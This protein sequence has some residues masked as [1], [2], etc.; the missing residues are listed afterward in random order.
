MKPNAFEYFAPNTVKEAVGLLER[1]EDEAKILAGG[2]SLVPIMNFRLGRPEVLVDINGIKDL[3]YIKEKGEALLIGALTRER[4][5]E[6]S[7]LVKEKCPILAEA[8]SF[9]GHVPIRNRGTIGGSLVHADPSSELPTVICCLNG[10][11]RVVSPLGER[12]L[13]PEEFFLT[14]LT[15]SL[16]PSEILIEVRVPTLPQNTAWSFVELTRRSG[17]FAI[18]GVATVLF[19]EDGGVCREAR[20][21]LGGVAPTPVRAEEAEELLSGQVITEELI[22]EAGEE[23]AE[24]TETEPDYHASAEYR[25]DMARVFV[26]R[27]L[28]EALSKVKG[29]K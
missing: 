12:A 22:Q 6:L 25:K 29:G 3:D 7:P 26:Q 10:E 17:D 20:I 27:G 15:T 19:M 8:V 5:L 9:I 13:A 28:H 23:A 2:Q 14:Y 24:A 21:A 16:E 1:Y 18:V 11:M 4:D